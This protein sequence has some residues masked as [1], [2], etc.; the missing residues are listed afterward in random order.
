MA[1][2]ILEFSREEIA[3]L[4]TMIICEMWEKRTTEE[5]GGSS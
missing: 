3:N 1:K 5:L 4:G 2:V